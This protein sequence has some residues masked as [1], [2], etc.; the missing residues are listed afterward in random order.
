[1]TGLHN[2]ATAHAFRQRDLPAAD[3][4]R[5][6]ALQPAALRACAPHCGVRGA[7]GRFAVRR[8]AW[9]VLLMVAAVAAAATAD[10]ERNPVRRH[11]HAGA[12]HAAAVAII[13]KLRAADAAL[14]A[15]DAAAGARLEALA[16]RAGLALQGARAITERLHVLQVA[17]REPGGTPEEL[18]A[19]LRADP[20]VQYA[21]LDQRRYVHTAPNDTLYSEQWYLMP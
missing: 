11:P 15:A 13:V 21:E 17:T 4:T 6:P 16:T 1:M 18:L 12:S 9:T 7:R 14:P 20:E 10:L 19:R 3:S 2:G 8:F 5:H